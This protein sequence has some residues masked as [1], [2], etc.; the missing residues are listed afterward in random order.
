MD[1]KLRHADALREARQICRLDSGPHAMITIIVTIL[2]VT[3]V[4]LASG[5]NEAWSEV[6]VKTGATAALLLIFPI[7]Y[8]WKL[9]GVDKFDPV[10][11]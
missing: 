11:S 1:W 3:F 4:W 5:P 9:G 7:V 10:T 6:I 2:A 8:L